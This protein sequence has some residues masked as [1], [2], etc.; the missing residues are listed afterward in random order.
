M[1][2]KKTRSGTINSVAIDSG[3]GHLAVIRA[4]AAGTESLSSA[5]LQ[6][7]KRQDI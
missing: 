2:N 7:W 1:Q 5:F 6:A 4:S 3:V